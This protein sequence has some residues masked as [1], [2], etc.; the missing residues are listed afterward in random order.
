MKKTKTLSDKKFGGDERYGELLADY[1]NV[2]GKR[3][4]WEE[5][6]REA[7]QELIEKFESTSNIMYPAWK[8]KEYIKKIFG[9]ELSKPSEDKT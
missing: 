7:M 8:A 3:A 1:P 4:F 2:K 6:V 5:D 9:D